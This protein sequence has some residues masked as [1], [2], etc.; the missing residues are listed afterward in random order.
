MMRVVYMTVVHGSHALSDLVDAT[1]VSPLLVRLWWI[2]FTVNLFYYGQVTVGEGEGR[3]HR[4][5]DIVWNWLEQNSEYHWMDRAVTERC[6]T[7]HQKT[8]RA[9]STPATAR[10]TVL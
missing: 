3:E 1:L 2:S 8:E 10:S 9:L 5:W 7:A 4:Q 6:A